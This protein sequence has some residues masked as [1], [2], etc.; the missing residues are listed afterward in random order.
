MDQEDWRLN[1]SNWTIFGLANGV[2]FN[3]P[4]LSSEGLTPAESG[5]A[6]GLDGKGAVGRLAFMAA[7]NAVVIIFSRL[8]KLKSAGPGGAE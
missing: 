6:Q 3:L 7:V 2:I 5:L 8:E 1:P 4:L